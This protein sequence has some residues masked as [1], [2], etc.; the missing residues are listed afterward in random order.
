MKMLDKTEP[1]DRAPNPNEK[2]ERCYC[3]VLPGG[4]ACAYPAIRDGWPAGARKQR[5]RA[6]QTMCTDY[7]ARGARTASLKA[8]VTLVVRSL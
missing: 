1:S 7:E 3:S 8:H 6:P 2:P 5:P 4:P